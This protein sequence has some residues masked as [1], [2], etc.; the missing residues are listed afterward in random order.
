MSQ[1]RNAFRSRT[2]SELMKLV[3]FYTLLC[4]AKVEVC[5]F[6]FTLN[7]IK[8]CCSALNAAEIYYTNMLKTIWIF[9]TLTYFN[10]TILCKYCQQHL[11]RRKTYLYEYIKK[12]RCVPFFLEQFA[13]VVDK[14]AK[15]FV[16]FVSLASIRSW[17]MLLNYYEIHNL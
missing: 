12:I 10:S 5:V 1:K 8:F 6:K 13:Q 4:E 7:Y 2:Q 3:M 15:F 11:L 16:I 17:K 14:H 9:A